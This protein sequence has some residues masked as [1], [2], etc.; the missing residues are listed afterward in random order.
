MSVKLFMQSKVAVQEGWRGVFYT[1]KSVILM[2]A[3]LAITGH[4]QQLQHAQSL[5]GAS[6]VSS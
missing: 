2:E 3:G 4:A 1:R 6:K 5:Q